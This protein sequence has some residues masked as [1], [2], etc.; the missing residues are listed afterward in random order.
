WIAIQEQADG[1]DRH[2][3][4]SGDAIHPARQPCLRLGRA[5]HARRR[6]RLDAALRPYERGVDVLRITLHSHV[7][8]ALLWLLQTAPRTAVDTRCHHSDTGDHDGLYGV[9]AALGPDEL[10]GRH[11]DYQ[12][13]L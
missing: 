7:P 11:G 6:L 4:L 3:H 12:P 5:D 1:D 13:I 8:R 9:C 2:W 10:L